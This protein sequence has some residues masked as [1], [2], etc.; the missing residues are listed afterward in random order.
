MDLAGGPVPDDIDG[1]SLKDLL[2]GDPSNHP[3]QHALMFGQKCLTQRA[4][5]TKQYKLIWNPTPE[6]R[7]HQ[8]QIMNTKGK[9]FHKAWLEWVAAAKTDP[10]AKAKVNRV[11]IHPEFEL[12]DVKADPYE[13]DNLASDPERAALVKKLHGD[14]K[15]SLKEMNDP[16]MRPRKK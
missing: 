1:F 16:V 8:E 4:I 5:R 2:E 3:R 10:D 6:K 14:L 12:Y 15:E 13:T 9:Y 11:L 7:Y